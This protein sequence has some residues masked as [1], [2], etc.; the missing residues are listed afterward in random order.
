MNEAGASKYEPLARHLKA[1]SAD[2]VRMKF[3]EIERVIGAKLP[4]S[5]DHNRAYWS[6]NAANSVLTKAWLAAGFRSEQ[7][8]LAARK[9]V[10]RRMET[11]ASGRTGGFAE[12]SG[13]P[14]QAMESGMKKPSMFGC[15]A[16]TIVVN[17]DLTEP[18]D[19][20]LAAYLD[21]T[22]GPFA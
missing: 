20:E 9:V 11:V 17:C 14:F 22:Y 7:V 21:E 4:P 18:A 16:G 6:N 19:P 3:S 15:M 12:A 5:A 2:L 1:Q 13:A 10:F 8:D